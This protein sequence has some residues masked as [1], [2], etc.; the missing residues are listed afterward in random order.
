MR[1][2]TSK[3]VLAMLV[4][5]IVA[6]GLL[7]SVA[8]SAYVEEEG[9]KYVVFGA[10]QPVPNLDPSIHYDWSTRMIQESVYDALAYYVG[11]PEVTLLG[12]ELVPKEPELVPWLAE[13]W[14]ATPDAKTWTFHLVKDAKFHNGDPVTA[15]AVRFSFVRTLELEQG[16]AWMFLPVLDKEGIEVVDDYTIV[17]HLKKPYA[18]FVASVPWWYIM[19]PNQVNAHDPDWLQDHEAG[20]GPFKIKEWRHGEYYWLEAVE[21]YW[22]GWPHPNHID[23]YI[24]KLVREAATQKIAIQKGEIDIAEGVTIDDFELLADYPG[25]YVTEDIGRTTFGIK[26][27]TQKGYTAIK[28]VRKAICYAFDYDALI[29]IYNGHAVLEDSPFPQGLSGYLSLA[30]ITYRQDLDKAKEYMKKA[31]FPDGGFSLEYVLVAGHPEETKIGLILKDCL[32]KIGID[33]QIVPVPWPEMCARGSTAETSPDMMAVY[34]TPIINDPDV[35]AIQ[36][37]P[38]SY[39]AYYASHFYYDRKVIELVDEARSISDWEKREELYEQIQRMVLEDAP[40]VLGML[41][42]RTWAFRDYVK[43]FRFSPVRFTSE[44]D[45]YWLYLEE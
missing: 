43:G 7:V 29:D 42:S 41:Y 1:V 35:V 36:Y 33:V 38:A 9:K 24:F 18:P 31:G 30:D 14:D 8:C 23:G 39:G 13:S 19:N 4:M 21:D 16:P 15:E 10:R 37:H 28:N 44:V 12:E 2:K 25:I 26:M 17:F 6:A 22:K 11:P 32:S 20:S 3:R 45:M 5:G 40:E 27:N 34:T